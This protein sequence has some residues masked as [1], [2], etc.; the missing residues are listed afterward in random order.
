M[1]LDSIANLGQYAGLH[2]RFKQAVEFLNGQDVGRLEPGKYEIDGA[3]LYAIVQEYETKPREQGVWEAH[4]RYYDIQCI[5]R[6][7]ETCGYAPI[8]SA[9]VAKA[10]DGDSDY[11][12]FAADGT[13][14]ELREG[15]F[16][17][18]APQD[19][20]MPGIAVDGPAP[21]KKIVIKVEI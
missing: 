5:V 2:P 18:F 11:A 19:V 8:G 7:R 3:R 9:E 10:Y 6:G 4:R 1:I 17:F 12:L 14:F 16:A 20:H 13:F 21:V 15:F